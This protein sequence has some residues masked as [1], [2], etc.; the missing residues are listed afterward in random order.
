VNFPDSPEKIWWKPRREIGFAGK[1]GAAKLGCS[2]LACL[3]KADV[4]TDQTT[5][6]A[7][8]WA[9]Y[10]TRLLPLDPRKALKYGTFNIRTGRAWDRS[11]D[12]W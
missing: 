1:V 5:T 2:N 10:G 11:P 3:R 12:P 6:G 8:S 7:F 4:L 9:G